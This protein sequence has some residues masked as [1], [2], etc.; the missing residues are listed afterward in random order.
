MKNFAKKIGVA[1]LGAIFTVVAVAIIY[2][3]SGLVVFAL[4]ALRSGISTLAAFIGGNLFLAI[5]CIVILCIG[6]CVFTFCF[7]PFKSWITSKKEERD[8]RNEDD[9][10]DDEDDEGVEPVRDMSM[11]EARKSEYAKRRYSGRGKL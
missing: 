2:L 8:S 4:N 1:L 9:D 5:V 10:D 3:V 6:S 11:Y 7:D